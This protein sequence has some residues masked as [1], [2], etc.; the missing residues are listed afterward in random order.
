M[1]TDGSQIFIIDVVIEVGGIFIGLFIEVDVF[2]E[3]VLIDDGALVRRV[4]YD[5]QHTV[6]TNTNLFGIAMGRYRNDIARI[7]KNRQYLR[8]KTLREAMSRRMQTCRTILIR[9]VLH[10]QSWH[11]NDGSNLI[12]NL[13]PNDVSI[14]RRVAARN[15][16]A[17]RIDALIG[18]EVA[19]K[20]DGKIMRAK[21]FIQ[22]LTRMLIGVCF[23][24]LQKIDERHVVDDLRAVRQR[25]ENVLRKGRVNLVPIELNATV[26]HGDTLRELVEVAGDHRCSIEQVDDCRILGNGA[27]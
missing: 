6:P 8:T 4:F 14:D 2:I 21:E 24:L 7:H 25:P 22:L 1:G 23:N 9:I 16:P 19:L 17:L 12:R 11:L 27:L 10:R 20:R 3:L 13:A 5:L 15:A 18:N 26:P